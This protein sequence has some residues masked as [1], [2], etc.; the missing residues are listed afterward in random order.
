MTRAVTPRAGAS[1]PPRPGTGPWAGLLVAAGVFVGIVVS[2]VTALSWYRHDM[3]AVASERQS[4]VAALVNGVRLRLDDIGEF[5]KGEAASYQGA[6][7]PS[8]TELNDQFA[9]PEVLGREPGVI[10]EFFVEKVDGD[11]LAHFVDR[12]QAEVSPTFQVLPS[13]AREEYWIVARAVPSSLSSMIGIDGRSVAVAAQAL[14]LSR[15]TGRPFASRTVPLSVGQLSADVG[16]RTIPRA[17]VVVTPVYRTRSTPTTV[18]ARRQQL[19]GWAGVVVV[20]DLFARDLQRPT[21]RTLGLSLFDGGPEDRNTALVGVAPS[22]LLESVE[23][24]GDVRTATVESLGLQLTVRVTSLA[25]SPSPSATAP[26]IV[27]VGGLLLSLLAGWLAVVLVLSRR[28]ALHLADEAIAELR[29][30]EDEMR[31]S[32]ARFASLVRRSSDVIAIVDTSGVVEFV[33]PSI[34]RLLALPPARIEGTSLFD[35]VVFD[36]QRVLHE[37]LDQLTAGHEV[38]TPAELVLLRADGSKRWLEVRASNLMDDPN[39][40]GI[41]LNGRDVTERRAYQDALT[42]EATHDRLTE[43]P[44]RAQFLQMLGRAEERAIGEGRSLAV[45]FVDID[46]FK[47]VNDSLGHGVGDALLVAVARRLVG[48]VRASDPVARLGGDEFVVVCEGVDLAGAK[49]VA[50]HVL[51]ACAAPFEIA[52]RELRITASVGIAFAEHA[53]ESAEVILR[54]ADIAMYEAKSAGRACVRVFDDNARADIVRRLDTEHALHK[55]VERGELRLYFQPIVR[56][57]DS[58]IVGAEALLRWAHPE[59]GLVLPGEF[60]SVS[61]DSDLALTIGDWVLQEAFRFLAGADTRAAVT[62]TFRLGVNL[63]NRHLSHAGLPARLDEL[64]RAHD[65]EPSTVSLE[66]TES[67]AMLDPGHVRKVLLAIRDQ[68]FSLA[69]DDFG[70]G[71]SSLSHVKRLPIDTLKIDRAFVDGVTADRDDRAIVAAAVGLGEALDLQVVAEGVEMHVQARAL[72]AL[73]CQIG[74]GFLYSAAVTGVELVA[75]MDSANLTVGGD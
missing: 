20:G 55:A 69:L 75:L 35:Y 65:V 9:L 8:Q 74:Q 47:V 17:I 44:N 33:T 43:L 49:M 28:R 66:I 22:D 5:V 57:A 48:A 68:G 71:Y 42:Y 73:G 40:R 1:A 21:E 15:D 19:K 26:L 34:E 51:A 72:Q 6:D 58:Q 7:L 54:N 29:V 67:A 25:P 52:G 61:E 50:Q 3:R 23:N 27:F 4:E 38:V 13:G 56:L 64:A 12:Q 60:L 62:P 31:K 14:T 30:S 39:V 36:E 16:A 63:S 46:H 41:V 18:D 2:A 24:Q 37:L 32:A 53:N 10:G 11:E 70:T 59:R 45:L